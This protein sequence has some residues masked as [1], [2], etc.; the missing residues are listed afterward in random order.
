MNDN[1]ALLGIIICLEY[2]HMFGDMFL[3]MVCSF[4]GR[5]E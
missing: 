4:G 1:D 5:L 2:R 3:K